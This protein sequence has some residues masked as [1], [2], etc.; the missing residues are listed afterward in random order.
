MTFEY[1]PYTKSQQTGSKRI[2]PTQR[3]MGDIRKSVDKSLKSVQVVF[4]KHVPKR[5]QRN[6]LI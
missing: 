6:G 3:Q 5:G 2:K 1:R 4:V